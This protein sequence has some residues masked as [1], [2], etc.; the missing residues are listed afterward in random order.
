MN[1]A[2]FYF[3]NTLAGR[4]SAL[5]RCGVFIT[6]YALY[7]VGAILMYYLFIYAPRHASSPRSMLERDGEAVR[8]LVSTFLA[9]AATYVLKVLTPAPRP[10]VTLDHVHQLVHAAAFESFPSGH[11]T[12]AMA[13]ATAVFFYHR[14]LGWW[15]IVYALLVGISRIYVGVHYPSDVLAGWALGF[16]VSRFIHVIF[17]KKFSNVA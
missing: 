14:R 11:A 6:N 2:I 7:I 17:S 13:M 5:D 10:F 12:V 15:L 16:L 1:T 9:W 8:V 4:S 3:F